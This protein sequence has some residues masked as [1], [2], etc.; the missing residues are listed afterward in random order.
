M[1]IKSLES[2]KDM[3]GFGILQM[4]PCWFTVGTQYF[5]SRKTAITLNFQDNF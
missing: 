3:E 2:E 4:G 1:I 5:S